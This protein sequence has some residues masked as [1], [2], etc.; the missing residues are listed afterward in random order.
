MGNSLDKCTRNFQFKIIFDRDWNI[1]T[2][3]T[4]LH[5]TQFSV[6]YFCRPRDIENHSSGLKTSDSISN[7]S[8]SLSI[9]EKEPSSPFCDLWV[10][11]DCPISG[12]NPK[13]FSGFHS[14]TVERET[15]RS[16]LCPLLRFFLSFKNFWKKELLGIRPSFTRKKNTSLV[17]SAS[18]ENSWKKKIP[19]FLSV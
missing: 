14:L 3:G 9:R 1:V 5:E 16:F 11:D 10:L 2:R 17:S 18:T 6:G 8:L 19:S 4:C 15:T 7:L 12:N 13:I